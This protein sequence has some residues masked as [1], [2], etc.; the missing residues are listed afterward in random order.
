MR[1]LRTLIGRSPRQNYWAFVR[2]IDRYRGNTGFTLADLHCT[3]KY[4]NPTAEVDRFERYMRV[5]RY[6]TRDDWQPRFE[7]A[8]VLELGCGPVLGIAPLAVFRGARRVLYSEPAFNR[9]LL[10]EPFVVDRYLRPLHAELCAQYA[11]IDEEYFDFVRFQENLLSRVRELSEADPIERCNLLYSN[12][13][14]EHIPPDELLVVLRRL[15]SLCTADATFIHVVDFSD[16][17]KGDGP[18]DAIYRSDPPADRSKRAINLLRPPEIS[19]HIREAGFRVEMH[20]YRSYQGDLGCLAD[21]WKDFDEESLRMK[22]AFFVG[23]PEAVSG[24]SSAAVPSV[25]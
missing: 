3:P 2:K 6:N 8:V 15:R 23:E 19:K 22:V 21:H 1:L 14:L 25:P 24:Q 12:S 16:H 7:D 10:G 18:F 5:L 11:P 4:L 9:E 17:W 13:V 20:P